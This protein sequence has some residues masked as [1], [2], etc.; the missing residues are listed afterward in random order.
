MDRH[1]Q[2][3]YEMKFQIEFLQARGDAFQRL[4]ETLMGKVYP[5]DFIACRPWGKTGD[6]KNDGYLPSKRKL[7]QV[8]APNQMAAKKAISKINEDFEGAKALS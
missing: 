1:Q 8:Y 2:L 3:F 5:E 4:F 6:R 7:F